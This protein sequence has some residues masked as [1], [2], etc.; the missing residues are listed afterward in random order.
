MLSTP[1]TSLKLVQA[2]TEGVWRPIRTRHQSIVS[3]TILTRLSDEL[4]IFDRRILI[5]NNHIGILHVTTAI[6]GRLKSGKDLLLGFTL[7]T[8]WKSDQKVS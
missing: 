6:T 5:N 4:G 7:W 3:T 2:Y 1:P 8:I